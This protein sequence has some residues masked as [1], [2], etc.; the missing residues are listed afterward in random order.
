MKKLS[1]AVIYGGVSGEHEVSLMSAASVMSAL[2]RAKYD[3]LPVRIRKDGRW[4]VDPSLLPPAERRGL[5]SGER[6]L[7]PDATRRGLMGGD[8]R[9]AEKIDVVLPLVHGTGG[10]D[11]SLQG[12]LELAG[13]P[14]VGSGVLGSAV[15]MDKVMQ[16]KV[17]EREGFPVAK[18][19]HFIA[20]DWERDARG[21]IADIERRLGYPNFVKPA[22]LGSSVGI[23]KAHHRKELKAG[24]VLAL[25]YDR[26]IMVERAVPQAREIECAVLGNDDPK[27]SVL[28]EI[29]S[30][31]EFYDY[32]AK[33]LDG[34]SA[35][36]IPA[37]LPAGVAAKVK[38]M[39]VKAFKTLDASGL[40]RVDFFVRRNT[41]DVFINEINTIPGFTSISMYPKL[42]EASGLPYP[43]LLDEL[44]RLARERADQ[45]KS[46]LREFAPPAGKEERG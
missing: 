34:K 25:S 28:G 14:Y 38:A 26:K 39:A 46:L 2:D 17:L 15:G 3:V 33:Y 9:P 35:T 31:N 42:W 44:I 12:L 45:K 11:G 10:E 4:T 29:V 19:A 1:I 22:N 18:Y 6:T 13:V 36:V 16:K 21:I 7:A 40:A 23:S 27:P 41:G 37:K 30:S 20:P 5:A 8:G 32:A 24:I 43:A